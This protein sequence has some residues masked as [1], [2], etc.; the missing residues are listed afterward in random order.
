MPSAEAAAK[1]AGQA[2]PGRPATRASERGGAQAP[3]NACP[4]AGWRV[5]RRQGVRRSPPERPVHRPAARARPGR[6]DPALLRRRPDPGRRPGCERRRGRLPVP[7]RA[8]RRGDPEPERRSRSWPSSRRC[9]GWRSPSMRSTA[10][11][12]RGRCPRLLAQPIYRDDVIN[13]KFAAGMAVIGVVLVSV[14]AVHRRRSACSGSGS[15][16]RPQEVLRL[17]A[18]VA[19]DV[20]VRGGLARVRAAAVGGRPSGGD[21]GADRL[22][23]LARR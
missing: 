8:R 14:V 4:R 23:D 7:L 6:R 13:G 16:P 11:D 18:W 22:R 10:S 9:S 3:T 15:C 17:V 5:D 12:P 20:P 1:D 21:G 2:R 19:R